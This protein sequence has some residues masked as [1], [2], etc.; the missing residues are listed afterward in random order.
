VPRAYWCVCTLCKADHGGQLILWASSTACRSKAGSSRLDARLTH[1]VSRTH[2]SGLT[3]DVVQKRCTDTRCLE[4]AP[5]PG[6]LTGG[7][8]AQSDPTGLERLEDM[9]RRNLV[10]RGRDRAYKDLIQSAKVENPV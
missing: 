5:E 6:S 8:L 1:A 7:P 9:R 2:S 4:N 10:I 3:D